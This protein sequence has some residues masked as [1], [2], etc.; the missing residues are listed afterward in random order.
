[1]RPGLCASLLLPPLLAAATASAEPALDLRNFHPPT[2]PQGS[3]FLEPTSTPGPGAWNAAA[4][5]SYAYRQIVIRDPNGVERVPLQH[6]LSL[7]YLASIG[8]GERLALGVNLPT[9]LYQD[10]DDIAP[11]VDNAALPRTA[12]GD[13]GFNAKATLL[14]TGELGGFGLGAIARLTTPTGN[15]SSYVSERSVTGELRLLAELRLI[16]V[17]LQATAGARVRGTEQT[18]LGE[19]F[20]HD[21]PWG[22]GISLRPQVLGIDDKGRW[23]WDLL[24]RGALATTPSLGASAQSPVL[25]GASA[26]YTVGEISAIAGV[27]LPITDAI[28]SPSVRAVLGLGWAPR[29]LDQDQ[30]GVSDDKDECPE[31]EEDLDGLED[32]DGCPEDDG[33]GHDMAEK[34][35]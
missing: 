18:Y 28:G 31:L 14:P 10:G 27:E 15:A 20:G 3:L 1:M 30:D 19:A 21:L 12:L 8:V 2:D 7:D 17:A 24:L 35:P 13:V 16:A 22:L 5:F 34:A 33:E 4:W 23:T 26:R 25:Y 11:L 32:S 9:I 6:Q 29:F